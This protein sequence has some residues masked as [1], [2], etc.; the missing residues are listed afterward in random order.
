MFLFGF[1]RRRRVEQ[2]TSPPAQVTVT[3]PEN[4]ATN[5]QLDMTIS[6]IKPAQAQSYNVYFGTVSDSLSFIDN[7]LARTYAP[8]GLALDMTYYF[9]IDSVNSKGTTTGD[10]FSFSTWSADDI[11]TD[12][13]GN[14]WTDGDG[15]YIELGTE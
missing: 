2:I 12:G 5:L 1:L 13:D 10:E 11:W 3:D 6:W 8:P 15:N 14:P 4:G 7:R 9:R